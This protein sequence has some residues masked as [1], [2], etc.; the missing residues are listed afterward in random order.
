[1]WLPKTFGRMN[2]L[3]N[4]WC[5]IISSFDQVITWKNEVKLLTITEE[6]SHCCGLK[7]QQKSM[8]PILSKNIPLNIKNTSSLDGLIHYAPYQ[9]VI[10]SFRR[11]FESLA[12]AQQGKQNSKNFQSPI[13]HSVIH[14]N[15]AMEYEVQN[16][17]TIGNLKRIVNADDTWIVPM[18]CPS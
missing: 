2:L 15:L 17:A 18:E 7:W 11:F 8:E 4:E 16:I 13:F 14:P 9:V 3:K 12:V 6:Q 5:L 1:M 10:H